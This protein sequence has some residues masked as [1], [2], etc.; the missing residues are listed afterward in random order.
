MTTDIVKMFKALSD[1][2]RLRTL[3]VLLKADEALCVCEL[4]DIL[5]E[6][7]Y[8]V[9]R[10]VKELKRAG[11][12]EENKQGKWVYYQIKRQNKRVH[13]ALKDLLS[14][15][16]EYFSAP[17]LKRIEKRLSLRDKGRCVVGLNSEEWKNIGE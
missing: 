5:E 14:T 4:V 3:W 15:M 10:Y 7:Q 17:E 11:L 2:N 16:D 6:S 8:N 1:R 12:L 13:R 9:S